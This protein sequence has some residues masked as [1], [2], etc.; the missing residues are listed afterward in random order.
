MKIANILPKGVVAI[1]L[2]KYI[3]YDLVPDQKSYRQIIYQYL[4]NWLIPFHRKKNCS[5]I[6]QGSILWNYHLYFLPDISNLDCYSAY[7]EG[8]RS[9]P[10][11]EV[12][13][14]ST[15]T[16]FAQLKQCIINFTTQPPIHGF[17]LTPSHQA[18]WQS[19][20]IRSGKFTSVPV[21]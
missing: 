4:L 6:F 8:I 18:E 13:S 15:W 12:F 7:W 19:K 16:L 2:L 20:I 9:N 5:E 1:G 11:T 21:G 3:G 17:D 10:C 14:V